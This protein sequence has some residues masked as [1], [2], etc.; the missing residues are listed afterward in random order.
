MQ[1]HIAISVLQS[2]ERKDKFNAVIEEENH[3]NL[4]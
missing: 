4:Y 1:V 2:F 3:E